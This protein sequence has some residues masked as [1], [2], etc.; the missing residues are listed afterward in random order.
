MI[1]THKTDWG[2]TLAVVGLL[3]AVGGTFA[4]VLGGRFVGLDDG[5]NIFLNPQMG[6]LSWERI[7]WAFGDLGTA[8]RYMPLGWLGFSAVFTWQGLEPAGYHLASLA[9]HMLAAVALFLAT[10]NILRLGAGIDGWRTWLAVLA[11]AA[12]AVHPLRTEAVA[13]ASGLLYTQATAFASV[14][15][16]LWTLRWTAPQRAGWLSLGSC[17][18]LAASL[19][20]YPIALGLPGVC[21]LLDLAAAKNIPGATPSRPVLPRYGL[22]RGLGG[23]GLVAG[24]VFAAPLLARREGSANFAATA[25]W[26]DFGLGERGV[27]ALYVWGRYL[28]QLVCPWGLSPVYTELYSF[29]P[30][31]RRVLLTAILSG[32]LLAGAAWLVWRRRRLSPGPLAGYSIM[33][34]PFLGLLEHP[35]IAHDR[36]AMLLH[37]V[38]FV[39]GACWLARMK[40]EKPRLVVSVILS[41][42]VLWGAVRARALTG[43]WRDQESM[44][45]RLRQMLPANAWAGYY[46]GNVPASVLFLEGR[47]AEIGPQLDQAEVGAPG[48]SAGPVRTEFAS[49]IR[50]HEEFMRQNWPGRRLAPEAVLHYL[51]GKSAQ[52]RQDWLTARAH[53]RATRWTAS[54]FGEAWQEEAWCE[55]Q[56]HDPVAAS[57]AMERT[58]SLR[59][60]LVAD[61]RERE[62]WTLLAA[63]YTARGE[64]RLATEI[65]ARAKQRQAG[66]SG[67]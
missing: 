63:I 14:A 46:L 50:Q 67:K 20:T 45:A 13:W 9:W 64:T 25:A 32:C 6:A 42:L 59:P 22:S 47:F 18:A 40:A 24:L 35:W 62:F 19:F 11:T 53:F 10:R 43:V 39:A 27:Q 66:P 44:H 31:E 38:W 41:C 17:A 37:P 29:H 48:W 5:N 15:L 21:W 2:S 51:H 1:F 28:I 30:L 12:W 36:Y 60:S 34:L 49:L 52:T 56:L 23:L 33:V 65:N 7:C 55:L 58:I 8:R 54:D 57:A 3:A 4:P 26:S 16:W 61:P